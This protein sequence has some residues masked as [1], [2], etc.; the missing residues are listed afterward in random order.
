MHIKEKKMSKSYGDIIISFDLEW[1]K[2]YKIKNGN[3][4]FC[5]SY[6]YFYYPTFPKR[7]E[8]LEFGFISHYVEN[9]DEISDL[10]ENADTFLHS[11]LNQNGIILGHQLSSDISVILRYSN[12]PKTTNFSELKELWHRRKTVDIF[13]KLRVFDTRYDMETFLK[14]KSRRLV[15][16][17]DEFSFIVTQPELAYSMT[18][19]QNMYYANKDVSIMEKLSVLNLRHSLSAALLF[20]YHQNGKKPQKRINVNKIVYRNLKDYYGYVN[21]K[22]F[23]ALLNEG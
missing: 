20:L 15:D 10:V 3:K 4:P 21:S 8:D 2:N 5:F 17:C 12:Q 16:V 6:I 1:T 22:E 11:F 18:K 19:M 14:Q 7:I 13:S 9:I 23:K